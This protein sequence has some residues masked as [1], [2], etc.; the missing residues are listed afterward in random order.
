VSSSTV[1][2]GGLLT[3]RERDEMALGEDTSK[4]VVGGLSVVRIPR[5]LTLRIAAI[6]LF[7][8]PLRKIGGA[9]PSNF[10]IRTLDTCNPGDLI[11]DPAGTQFVKH[12]LYGPYL[13]QAA[14]FAAKRLARRR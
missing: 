6:L 13:Q 2:S 7:G 11:C 1:C 5:R 12:L 8:N 14:T 4:A 9:V 3:R 10:C